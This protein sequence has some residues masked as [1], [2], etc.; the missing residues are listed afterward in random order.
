MGTSPRTGVFPTNEV[1]PA[2]L[3]KVAQVPVVDGE[4]GALLESSRIDRAM[5]PVLQV[6]T[7]EQKPAARTTPDTLT[8]SPLSHA[9]DIPRTKPGEPM[10]PELPPALNHPDVNPVTVE[11]APLGSKP[12]LDRV[13][14]HDIQADTPPKKWCSTTA[15][16][17]SPGGD[18]V[19][20]VPR[21]CARLHQETPR[22]NPFRAG[23]YRIRSVRRKLL[24]SSAGCRMIPD[25][26][27]RNPSST[28]GSRDD[29]HKALGC[30]NP[31]FCIR[32]HY[33]G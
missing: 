16:T 22:A 27:S 17:L 21:V 31:A 33:G 28:R 9:L 24:T 23:R 10:P 32:G 14:S 25:R 18:E 15:R 26:F 4:V 3:L 20:E 12:H 6:R 29:N 13:F 1:E 2:A 5:T 7:L 11:H 30:G 19:K 8:P